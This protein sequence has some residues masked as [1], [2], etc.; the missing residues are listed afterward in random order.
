MGFKEAGLRGSLRNVSV[1]ASVIPDS[2]VDNYE[3]VL[4]EDQDK[5]LSDYYNEDLSAATRQTSTVLKGDFTLELS[6]PGDNGS[7]AIYSISGLPRYPSR[8]D[9][10]SLRVSYDDNVSQI[11]FQFVFGD[12]S[13]Q[14]GTGYSVVTDTDNDEMIIRKRNS[15][16]FTNIE[17]ASQTVSSNT[18]YIYDVSFGSPTITFTLRDSEG[19]SL[20]SISVDDDEFDSGGIRLATFNR[21]NDGSAFFDA[22]EV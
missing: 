13:S 2:V 3:Q 11:N 15:S 19:N 12:A 16:S 4:Y 8:G 18:E 21:N 9:D 6:V 7:A 20:N 1:G 22:V 14:Y 10:L 17:E 5:T